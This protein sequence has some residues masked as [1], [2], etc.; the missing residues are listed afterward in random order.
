M[1]GERRLFVRFMMS[2][3]VI[4]QPDTKSPATIECELLDLSY[5]GIGLSSPQPIIVENVRFIIINRQLNVNLSGS[6]RVV[7]CKT[8]KEN[9]KNIFRVGLEFTD[10]DRNQIKSILV[11]V[12]DIPAQSG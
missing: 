10:V 9:G 8:V 2:G 11:Q 1:V 5:D 3:M 12:R 6:A 4:L 7:Y